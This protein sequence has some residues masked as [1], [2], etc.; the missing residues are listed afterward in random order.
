MKI[1]I[2][3]RLWESSRKKKL[4]P[5]SSMGSGPELIIVNLSNINL[6]MKVL[7]LSALLDVD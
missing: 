3:S 6:G 4:F 7:K 5:V 1:P 2:I